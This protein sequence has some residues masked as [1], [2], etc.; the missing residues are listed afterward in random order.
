MTIPQIHL[1]VVFHVL[2]F[3]PVFDADHRVVIILG[4]HQ[5]HIAPWTFRKHIHRN[6]I[7]PAIVVYISNIRTH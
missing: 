6:Q 3:V 4:T 7:A 5:G 1:Q 2:M